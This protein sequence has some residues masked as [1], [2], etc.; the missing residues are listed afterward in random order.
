MTENQGHRDEHGL[1]LPGLVPGWG[2]SWWWH[3]AR[4]RSGGRGNGIRPRCRRSSASREHL[5]K[6]TWAF[7]EAHGGVE[8]QG[9][10]TFR[11]GRDL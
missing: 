2:M 1:I 9:L 3:E 8:A 5:H 10:C 7:V 4:S 11:P 6:P